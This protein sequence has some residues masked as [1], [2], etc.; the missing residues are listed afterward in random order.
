MTNL[1]FLLFCARAKA[2][3]S[4][5]HKP[6]F[7]RSFNHPVRVLSNPNTDI[8]SCNR[9]ISGLLKSGSLD[10]ALKLFDEMPERDVITWNI[11]IS[12]HYRLGL[13]TESLSLYN[14]MVLDCCVESSST[15]STVLSICS[16]KG[17]FREGCEVHCRAVV[18]GFST[19]VYVGSA[20]V[21]LYLRMGCTGVALRLFGKLQ[22]R[23]LATWNVALRGMCETGGVNELFRMYDEMRLEGV[24]PN[25]VTYCYLIR[26][27]GYERC[28]EGGMQLHCCV[29]KGGLVDSDLFVANALVDFYSACGS[30]V[31]TRKVFEAIPP[32]DVI[33]WNSLVS[34]CAA[35]GCI[36]DGLEAFREMRLWDKKPSACSFLGFLKVSSAAR[37]L[38]FGQQTHCSVLKAGL[39]SVLVQSALIDM[40]GKCGEIGD[41]VGIFDGVLERNV[42]CCNSLMT[43]LLKS[44]LLEDVVDLFGVM[45]DE[46][47]GFDEVSLSSA[48]KALAGSSGCTVLHC[49]AVK[50]GF[51]SDAAVACALI[52]AYSRAGEV[53]LS[54]RVFNLLPSP[55]VIC[56]TS[57]ISALARNGK[58]KECLEM[59]DL[60][61][62][63]GLKPDKVTFLSALMGCSH[64]GLVEEGRTVFHSMETIH[65]LEPERQHYSCMVD[66]LGRAGLLEEATEMMKDTPWED[67]FVIWS[68]VLRS[69]R[70]HREEQ[71]G[72]RA[73]KK[74]IDLQPENPSSWLQASY[75]YS[76]IGDFE[77]TKEYREI[78]TARK[79]RREIGRSMIEIK[80]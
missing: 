16:S 50:S 33:S 1:N 53:G 24:E 36:R 34:V 17:L 41:A 12:G 26:G 35:S 45:V 57:V 51:E 32:S 65:G 8:Y 69:C 22:E 77:R 72:S 55:N 11:M 6:A 60:M 3:I 37:D 66:L 20:L 30:L 80:S 74:L 14:Q 23:N 9:I 59:L 42:E 49:C 31:E 43:S 64:S 19:N 47:I 62:R 2:I 46:G 13:L 71:L 63:K 5:I 28:L 79:V 4:R 29:I 21:D 58:G 10:S 39:D 44:E 52:D 76:D 48:L 38:V 18:L 7:V 25:G 75:F 27:C 70:N 67:D 56:F 78:A 40:Y 61:I 15:F 54:C 68:S 73:A